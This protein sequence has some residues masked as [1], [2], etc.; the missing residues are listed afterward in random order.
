MKMEVVHGGAWIDPPA[1]IGPLY[2]P[3]DQRH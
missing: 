2:D 3:K 1:N